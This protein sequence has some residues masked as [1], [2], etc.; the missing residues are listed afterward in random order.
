VFHQAFGWRQLTP[1]RLRAQAGT[2]YDVA[3]LTK[4]VVTS[5]AAMQLCDRGT[6]ALDDRVSARLP[7]FEGPGK[8]R[9]TIRDLLALDIDGRSL[10]PADDSGYGFDNIADVLSVS[11]A[12]LERYLTA[13]RKISRLAVGDPTLNRFYS[14]HYLL[15]FVITGVVVLHIWPLHMVG[16]NNPAGIEPKTE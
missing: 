10:L 6:L 3:S 7:E 15:P 4:A 12:L 11:P 13:A 5:V 14:L 9:C 8:E 16:Q 1:R 2:V